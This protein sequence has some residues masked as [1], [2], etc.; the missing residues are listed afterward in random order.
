MG[1]SFL[2]YP[3]RDGSAGV[4]NHVLVL[5]INGLVGAAA[6][7]IGAAVRGTVTVATPY[8]RGQVGPDAAIHARQLVGLGRNPNVAAA[9]IVGVDRKAL[10]RVAAEIAET[11]TVET[12]ALDD[13][14]EDALAL[15]DIGIRKAARLV[16]H[17]SGQRRAACPLSAL[18]VG[19]ECGHSDATS[20]L[21]VNPLVGR[22]ADRV[23]DGGGTVI[24]GETLEWLGAEHLLARRAAT[25]EVAR[26][27]TDAVARREA[28]P[29]SLGIDL[30]GNN[31]GEENIRGG[32]STI[33][34]KSLGAV[35]KGGNRAIQSVLEH[36]QAPRA[37][38]LVSTTTTRLWRASSRP[39]GP[40]I[41]RGRG[42]RTSTVRTDRIVAV[43]VACGLAD[44][45]GCGHGHD[46][47]RRWPRSPRR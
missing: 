4:R 22:V 11:T 24:I 1:D 3:R 23:V 15:S 20:G 13:T 5:G 34:E 29:A 44:S 6:R 42:T 41:G 21:A 38:W 45:S 46:R 19:V 39:K 30:L 32:L 18:R 27:V 17:V 28:Y 9:V 26:A 8:G 14:H 36:A 33:E 25:P 31:P 7:R 47:R 35:A 40:F 37:P 16:R 43:M 12:V 10:D 2:G